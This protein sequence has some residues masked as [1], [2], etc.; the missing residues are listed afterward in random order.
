MRLTTLSAI[1][2]AA[3]LCAAQ[4]SVWRDKAGNMSVENLASW[5]VTQVSD[6]D[7]RLVGKGT[8]SAPVRGIWRSQGFEV[9]AQRLECLA[10]RNKAGA[11]EMVTG[12]ASG[13]CIVTLVGGDGGA[14]QTSARALQT[15]VRT[16]V[17][18]YDGAERKLSAPGRL[19]W[20]SMDSAAGWRFELT[21]SGGEATLWDPASKRSFPA[22]EVEIRGPV[23][24]SWTSARPPKEKG[25]QPSTVTIRGRADLVRLDDEA[26]TITLSGNVSASGDE[27]PFAG[28]MEASKVVLHYDAERRLTQIEG[29]GEP[30]IT[31]AREKGGGR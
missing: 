24:M 12:E 13:D 9:R 21:G 19:E 23:Q 5:L 14:L 16:E 11:Y 15:T 28:S 8:A 27:D 7:V 20:S 29:F 31:R 4:S 10:R 26:R 17:W 1:A 3:V 22:R 25:G 30:G 6:T 2:L 18:R